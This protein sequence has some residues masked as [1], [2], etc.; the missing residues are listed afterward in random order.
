[1]IEGDQ[2]LGLLAGDKAVREDGALQ[3][4]QVAEADAVQYATLTMEEA[5]P[6]AQSRTSTETASPRKSGGLRVLMP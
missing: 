1:M 2:H 6:R 4:A 3:T 5:T